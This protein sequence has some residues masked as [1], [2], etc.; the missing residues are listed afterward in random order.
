MMINCS[1]RENFEF[2]ERNCQWRRTWWWGIYSIRIWHIRDWRWFQTRWISQ[3]E[4]D[5]ICQKSSRTSYVIIF[6]NHTRLPGQCVLYRLADWLKLNFS[7]LQKTKLKECL[8]Q[9]SFKPPNRAI[10]YESY[11]PT[12]GVF[13]G[14]LE[15]V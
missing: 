1:A 3:Y 6:G 7:R 12:R 10:D 11:R 5:G 8:G 15:S 13:Y 4:F 2:T 9:F 14:L